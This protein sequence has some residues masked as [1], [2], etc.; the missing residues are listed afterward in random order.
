MIFQTGVSP[1]T[2]PHPAGP[3]EAAEL[4]QPPARPHPGLWPDLRQYWGLPA[5][6]PP[7][8]Q[9]LDVDQQPRPGGRLHRPPEDLVLRPPAA[10]EREG[11][12][13]GSDRPDLQGGTEGLGVPEPPVHGGQSGETDDNL[14]LIDHKLGAT[15]LWAQLIITNDLAH[16]TPLTDWLCFRRVPAP[17]RWGRRWGSWR[18]TPG[19]TRW[20]AGAPGLPGPPRPVGPVGGTP[21]WRSPPPSHPLSRT[22]R[23]TLWG[24]RS[25]CPPPTRSWTT[26]RP[27]RSPVIRPVTRP[28]TR[29]ATKPVTRPATPSTP[30]WDQS[31]SMDTTTAGGRATSTPSP[32]ATVELRTVSTPPA[33]SVI[34]STRWRDS[35]GSQ[36]RSTTT[37]TTVVSTPAWSCVLTRTTIS[38]S[39]FPTCWAKRKPQRAWW[40]LRPPA[41]HILILRKSWKWLIIHLN[42]YKNR[43]FWITTPDR[44]N[45]LQ[46]WPN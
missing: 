6:F 9:Q 24:L 35:A 36:R 10:G 23:Q 1:S 4:L 12:M 32:A 29:P 17:V 45:P 3:G 34:G 38:P 46:I 11:E 16:T 21:W 7:H 22:A 30:G 19:S 44:R 25:V 26:R 8:Q 33:V 40:R 2:S 31:S 39:L 27:G 18:S 41:T 13:A 15:P 5:Q 42:W 37:T 43:Q 20:Q 28:V 14:Y